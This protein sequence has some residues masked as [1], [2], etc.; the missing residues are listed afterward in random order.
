VID[1]GSASKVDNTLHQTYL[2]SRYYRAPEVILGLGFDE[3][4]D[5]WS[6]GCVAS[7]LYLGQ[8]LYP[9]SSEYDQIRFIVETQGFPSQHMLQRGEKS[10]RFFTSNPQTDPTSV[11]LQDN[12]TGYRLKTA[13][14]MEIDLKQANFSK[15]NR[16]YRF[17]CLD[18]I[19]KTHPPTIDSMHRNMEACDA[20]EFLSLLRQMMTLDPAMRITPSD[21]LK[22]N[23]VT[24][25]HLSKKHSNIDAIYYKQ[26]VEAMQVCHGPCN[27]NNSSQNK[28]QQLQQPSTS[29]LFQQAQQPQYLHNQVIPKSQPTYFNA[30]N[31]V[32][33]QSNELVQNHLKVQAAV[34]MLQPQFQHKTFLDQAY[35]DS[36]RY[37]PQPPLYPNFLAAPPLV[38]EPFN[39]LVTNMERLVRQNY[40]MDAAAQLQHNLAMQQQQS[41][42]VQQTALQSQAL[43]QQQMQHH[44][45][46]MAQ[47]QAQL[48]QQIP[49]AVQN[50]ASRSHHQQPSTSKTT[51]RSNNH[52]NHGNHHNHHGNHHQGNR[53]L[54]SD[55]P[56]N[57]GGSVITISSESDHGDDNTMTSSVAMETSNQSASRHRNKSQHKHT[58]NLHATSDMTSQSNRSQNDVTAN[59]SDVKN[60][61]IRSANADRRSSANN[62]SWRN[63]NEQM[64][65]LEEF[66]RIQ[67]QQQQQ[68]V[69]NQQQMVA[70]Q[71]QQMVASQQ[72]MVHGN[73]LML[74]ATVQLQ[75]PHQVAVQPLLPYNAH[76]AVEP[77]THLDGVQNHQLDQQRHQMVKMFNL[78][79]GNQGITQ[80]KLPTHMRPHVVHQPSY[81]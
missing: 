49:K 14:E 36:L 26:S 66:A 72:Q 50:P 43:Q 22:Y 5:M 56:V 77:S 18:D 81:F 34:S 42:M 4:I 79:P 70:N 74:P 35:L 69:A 7:E 1:F 78:L 71:Q 58:S 75:P 27:N 57:G 23:F 17:Q 61:V 48:Q 28:N 64:I 60:D 46:L 37:F 39:P 11:T 80:P 52:S 65:N 40:Y 3:K 32:T 20:H 55:S 19:I 76:H 13:R 47:Q 12:Y 15:E 62:Q 29:N 8:P 10:S 68:M 21:A 63:K 59:N 45:Q 54:I 9:G 53:I 33:Q 38:A 24:M 41:A 2:Q 16:K 44:N 67:Q 25:Q 30:Y 6:L 31:Q 73:Q 51:R